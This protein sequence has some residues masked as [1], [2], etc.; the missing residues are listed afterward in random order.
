MTL[1]RRTGFLLLGAGLGLALLFFVLR[2]TYPN[3]DSYYTLIWGD[4]LARGNLPDYD[5]FRTPTPHPLSTLLAALLSPFGGAADRI[6]V[7]ITLASFVAL[8]AAL[9]RFTQILLGSLIALIAALV[10]LTRT[11]LIFFSTR[12]VVDVPFLALIFWAAVL[13]LQKPRRGGAVMALLILAGLLRPEAWIFSGAYVIWL[14][15]SGEGLRFDWSVFLKWTGIA[16]IA[17]FLWLLSDLIV[18]GDPFYSLTST[19][20]VAGQFGRDRGVMS[21]IGSIPDY[22]GGNEKIVNVVA[23]GLGGVFALFLL[24][25]RALMPLALVGIGGLVFLLVAAAGLSVIPRYLVIPSLIF[26]LCVAVALAGWTLAEYPLAGRIGMALAG[27]ALLL[28]LFR[29][30]SYLKDLQ[31]LNGQTFFVREQ[32]RDLK[33]ILED[34]RVVPLLRDCGPITTPTH[35]AIPVI[36]YET[37]LGKEDLQAS[38]NQERP[39]AAGLLLVGETFNFEPAAAR[40]T[41]G[42]ASASARKWWS[43]YPLEGFELVARNPKWRVYA[44]CDSEAS[45]A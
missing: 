7:L 39:P 4:E 36:R 32:Y 38:I 17:P 10:V 43:N 8:I 12:A 34:P 27:F 20:E 40:A 33:A 25:R 23:G 44:R 37:G 41:S 24:R 14:A 29:A 42:P 45:A 26:N 35:S 31:K 22:V 3:Y 19:R 21:A 18:T 30:P 2:P 13:E 16:L 9:F 1:S 15:W 5:V 6:L 28:G 11:D